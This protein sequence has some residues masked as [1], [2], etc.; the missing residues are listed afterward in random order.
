MTETFLNGKNVWVFKPSD[1]N[2]GRGVQMFRR[3]SELQQL[4]VNSFMYG[5]EEVSYGEESVIA[6]VNESTTV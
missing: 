1:M 4:I 3:L 5:A 6:S 2:R